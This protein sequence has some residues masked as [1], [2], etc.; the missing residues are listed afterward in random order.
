MLCSL[1]EEV[2][3][4]RI[5]NGLGEVDGNGSEN[6]NGRREMGCEKQRG[7]RDSRLR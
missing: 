2:A 4:E 1:V 7:E 5:G 6:G 3:D